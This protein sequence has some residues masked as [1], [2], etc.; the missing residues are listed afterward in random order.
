MDDASTSE[1]K[2]LTQRPAK[3]FVPWEP[4]KAACG[5]NKES[6][7]GKAP[8]NIPTLFP[9]QQASPPHREFVFD[10]I[11]FVDARKER[12]KK[13]Q[14]EVEDALRDEIEKLEMKLR[15]E[16]KKGEELRRVLTATMDSDVVEYVM[17][18]SHDKARLASMIEEYDRKR[19]IDSDTV[20]SLTIERDIWR[21]KYVAMTVRSHEEGT[22]ADTAINMAI[23]AHKLLAEVSPLLAPPL[24][25][26][27]MDLSSRP[28][29]HLFSR[30]PCDEK[31]CPRD[32][33]YSNLTITCC[34]KCSG[35]EIYLL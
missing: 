2:H 35:R 14:T 19:A 25:T 15:E 6:S 7:E 11:P 24:S 33:I 26:Q 34:T 8:K 12:M 13:S 18:M 1:S 29:S 32:P 22:R 3:R 17:S 27:S 23:Q 9:Y 20:E 31:I 5:E 4:H 21:S 16:R 30:S 10:G 28:I